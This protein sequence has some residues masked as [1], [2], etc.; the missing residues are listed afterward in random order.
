MKVF[1]IINCE[2][3]GKECHS[4]TIKQHLRT[5]GVNIPKKEYKEIKYALNHDGLVCQFCG[6]ECKN[7][8]S[9]CNHERLCK[10]N[11]DGQKSPF[12][13]ANAL[14][15][16]IW[17]KGQ[18]KETN[19]SV[20]KMSRT[21]QEGYKSGRLSRYQPMNDPEVRE[22]HKI[23]VRKAYSKYRENPRKNYKYGRYKGIWCDSSWELAYVLYCIDNNIKFERNKIG[24]KYI[25]QE[26]VHT[27]FPDFYLP[28]INTYVEIKGRRSD[29]DNA[30]Q[31]Q[32]KY[33]LLVLN[34]NE[35]R[36]ILNYVI[37]KYGKNFTDLYDK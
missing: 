35:M 5:H 23:A 13:E 18:T 17:N 26:S 36:P 27:Y 14:G 1:K 34:C 11:P 30:K 24:F 10:N 29:R 37:N 9:L 3:C 6:K 2:I 12:I 33:N 25:W 28:D 31:E 21:L 4:N 32:F 7:R 15:L 20:A 22:K 8:N 19:E 16:N